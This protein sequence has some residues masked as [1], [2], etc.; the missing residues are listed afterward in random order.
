MFLI[1]SILE[2]TYLTRRLLSFEERLGMSTVKEKALAKTAA[3]T[4]SSSV[5]LK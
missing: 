2:K 4:T 3:V 5:L 1:A